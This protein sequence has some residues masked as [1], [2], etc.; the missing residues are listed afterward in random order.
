MVFTPRVGIRVGTHWR[1]E[2]L[3]DVSALVLLGSTFMSSFYPHRF[4]VKPDKEN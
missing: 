2:S 4:F 3:C 1:P